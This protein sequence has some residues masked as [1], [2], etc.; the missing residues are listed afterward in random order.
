M[1]RIQES[2]LFNDLFVYIKQIYEIIIIQINANMLKFNPWFSF[3]FICEND[4]NDEKM[5]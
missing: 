2:I 1:K 3:Q 5:R 4:I